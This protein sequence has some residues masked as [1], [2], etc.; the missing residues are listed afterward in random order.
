MKRVCVCDAGHGG[1]TCAGCSF[2]ATGECKWGCGWC[3]SASSCAIRVSS[4]A[5]RVRGGRNGRVV[6]QVCVSYVF[7]ASAGQLNNGVVGTVVA[8]KSWVRQIPRATPRSRA[9]SQAV[10]RNLQQYAPS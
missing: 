3:I 5:F 8:A 4:C 6:I 1:N 7:S 2:G 10:R 9:S